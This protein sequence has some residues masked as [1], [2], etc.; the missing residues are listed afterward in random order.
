MQPDADTWSYGCVASELAAWIIRGP[1][2]LKG[3]REGRRDAHDAAWTERDCF[4]NGYQ[5]LPYIRKFHDRLMEDMGNNPNNA[6]VAA[7]TIIERDMLQFEPN[8]R[9]KPLQLM[10]KSKAM[11]DQV[12][13]NILLPDPSSSLG[14]IPAVERPEMRQCA[15]APVPLSESVET[16]GAPHTRGKSDVGAKTSRSV[17]RTDDRSSDLHRRNTVEPNKLDITRSRRERFSD[18]RTA[19]HDRRFTETSDGCQG[20]LSKTAGST[21]KVVTGTANQQLDKPGSA[22]KPFGN[23]HSSVLARTDTGSFTESAASESYGPSVHDHS[24]HIGLVAEPENYYEPPE[25][26]FEVK[27][28]NWAMDNVMA[29]DAAEQSKDKL[30]HKTPD[31]PRG[32]Q[33]PVLKVH[34]ALSWKAETNSQS[35]FSKLRKRADKEHHM[36]WRQL[37]QEF[38]DSDFVSTR[39]AQLW[40]FL[41]PSPGLACRRFAFDAAVLARCRGLCGVARILHKKI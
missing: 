33:V 9:M 29:P 41:T 35:L 26:H 27:W 38:E 19:V 7:L 36:Y 22:D 6:T 14:S 30:P 12:Q 15:S 34:N 10:Y 2:G 32:N 4:H 18:R 5:T 8:N 11:M 24:D 25:T 17:N 40:M 39:Q 3:Y 1:G 23:T 28:P 31:R 20:F 21:H 37:S 13:K 16:A